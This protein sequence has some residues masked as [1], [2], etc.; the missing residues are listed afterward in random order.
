MLKK[1]LNSLWVNVIQV[2]RHA[3]CASLAL[4]I[5]IMIIYGWLLRPNLGA[6]QQAHAK[7]QQQALALTNLQQQANLCIKLQKVIQSDPAALKFKI[8]NAGALK[9]SPV[10]ALNQLINDAKLNLVSIDSVKGSSNKFEY[11]TLH[12]QGQ[13][14]CIV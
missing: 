1:H 3:C 4:F 10:V 7:G 8:N 11:F 6:A 14:F 2:Y 13:F 9:K 12:L 5:A